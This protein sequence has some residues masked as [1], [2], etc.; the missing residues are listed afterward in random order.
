MRPVDFLWAIG[1]GVGG[2]VVAIV[3]TYLVLGLRRVF[4]VAPRAVRPVVGGL[5]LAL[6]ALWS[7]YT[8]TFGEQQTAFILQHRL[9][10]RACS[11]VA[12]IAKLLGT[13]L[14]V[15]SGWPGG[16]IIPLFFMG[17]TLG[18]LTAS[19]LRRR[20]GRHRHRRV[21]GRDQCGRHQDVLGSTLVVTEMGGIRLLP[22]RCSRHLIAMMFTSSVGLIESQRDRTPMD[23][24]PKPN[25]R[26]ASMPVRSA[27]RQP[28]P[29][30]LSMEL[31]I[32]S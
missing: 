8:L 26:D 25:R 28:K 19:R 16:F 10:G 4:R 24:A 11:I 9:A 7:P 13:S 21:H 3:F 2:A 5:A 22:R 15:S 31:G 12:L 20:P 23:P 32:T 27:V 29:I 17:A 18:E 6:V 1:A 30:A 14:T